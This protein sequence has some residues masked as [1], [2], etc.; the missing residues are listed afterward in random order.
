MAET[1]SFPSF[2]DVMP[3]FGGCTFFN[4]HC[5]MTC[6][7]VRPLGGQVILLLM[8]YPLSDLLH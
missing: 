2:V 3:D 7:Q 4:R 6:V 5:S 8:S 1:V